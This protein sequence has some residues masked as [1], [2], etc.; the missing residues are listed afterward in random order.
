MRGG[1]IL[2]TIRGLS[3]RHGA[4]LVLDNVEADVKK[5]EIVAIT[6]PSGVGKST[7]LRCLNYLEPFDAGTIGVAGFTLQPG[8]LHGHRDLLRKLRESVGMVFQQFHLFPH[9]TALQNITLAPRVVEKIPKEEA[10][11]NALR[12]LERVGLKEKA[13]AFPFQLSGGQQQRVAIARTLA[14]KPQVMLFDE[15]TS[16]LDPAMREEVLHVM[17]ELGKEEMTMLVVTHETRFAEDVANR[18][19]VMQA[20]KIMKD[21][22]RV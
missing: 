4:H 7:L 17:R 1:S 16:A 14:Q 13:S 15:P 3:K 22:R 5:G 19:W 20:G 18:I 6:G 9:L 2:I 10:E 11:K 21:E 12:L 8:M